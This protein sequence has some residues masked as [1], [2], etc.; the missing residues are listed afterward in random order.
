MYSV[1]A[2]EDQG[3]IPEQMDNDCVAQCWFRLFHTLGNPV[4]L[5][6]PQVIG[7]T[8]KFLQM[9]LTSGTA[10]DPHKHECLH[11]LPK[12]FHRGMKS[13][14]VLVDAFLGKCSCFNCFNFT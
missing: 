1:S 13:V 11:A 8:N 12:I 2:E 9:A 14:S 5:S 10:M 4:D 7:N 6:R 3:L